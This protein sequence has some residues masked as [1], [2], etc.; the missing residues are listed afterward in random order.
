[1]RPQG[2]TP[3]PRSFDI[4]CYILQKSYI[5]TCIYNVFVVP[6]HSLNI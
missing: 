1:M 4:Y 2:L 6:L 3:S 5:K